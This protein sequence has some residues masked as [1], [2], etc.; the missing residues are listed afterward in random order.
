MIADQRVPVSSPPLAGA[1]DASPVVIVEGPLC[2]LTLALVGVPAVALMG[3]TTPK[4]LP[5]ALALRRVVLAL[6]S[7]EAGDRAVRDTLTPAFGIVGATVERWR[8]AGAKDW[9]DVLRSG[10]TAVLRAA[11]PPESLSTVAAERWDDA[12]ADALVGATLD[13]LSEMYDRLPY[14]RR[15]DS[16]LSDDAEAAISAAY[17][18]R[19]IP[20]LRNAL[21][22]YERCA[23]DVFKVQGTDPQ[24]PKG[25]RLMTMLEPVLIALAAIPHT[26]VRA[27]VEMLR[28]YHPALERAK[29]DH[30]QN[31][32]VRSAGIL[33]AAEAERRATGRVCPGGSPVKIQTEAPTGI[34][35]LRARFLMVSPP[36]AS[37]AATLRGPC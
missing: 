24:T 13:R 27:V 1:L 4:W 34:R 29:S 19:E 22:S 9:N 35:R 10:G 32:L 5:R 30:R 23:A 26:D 14:G 25:T 17:T 21:A 12:L 28:K 20:R 8:P 15:V 2:A 11:L 3:T 18:A 7:D 16:Q 33:V 37:P 36:T 6:D 31:A